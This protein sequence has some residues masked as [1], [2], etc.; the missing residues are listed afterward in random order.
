MK[1]E[2]F[3]F[4]G[5]APGELRKPG[6]KN[7]KMFAYFILRRYLEWCSGS[8]TASRKWTVWN[9]RWQLYFFFFFFLNMWLIWFRGHLSTSSSSR[10]I[11]VNGNG[12]TIGLVYCRYPGNVWVRKWW[13][14]IRLCFIIIDF[15][16]ATGLT[17]WWHFQTLFTFVLIVNIPP[18]RKNHAQ[19]HQCVHPFRFT[20][21]QLLSNKS[22]TI[23]GHFIWAVVL[24]CDGKRFRKRNNKPS[25]APKSS[26]T[27]LIKKNE[28]GLSQV[29]AVLACSSRDIDGGRVWWRWREK[30]LVAGEKKSCVPK[31]R[32]GAPLCNVVRRVWKHN[33]IHFNVR[34]R[35]LVPYKDKVAGFN[36]EKITHL[37][38]ANYDSRVKRSEEISEFMMEAR[39]WR[40]GRGRDICKKKKN[41]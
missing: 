19:V 31:I 38:I 36:L 23:R 8:A 6:N 20:P 13:N 3:V 40:C 12:A 16:I 2:S 18:Q 26:L 30:P 35:N 21:C 25:T 32:Q 9:G 17:W 4:S 24:V 39:V 37:R 34:N 11:R 10:K 29:I 5:V 22:S 27:L 41:Q 28:G 14:K 15:D 7:L 1:R 33:K